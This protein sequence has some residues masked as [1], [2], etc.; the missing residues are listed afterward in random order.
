MIGRSICLLLPLAL[1]AAA[2][3]HKIQYT[4]DGTLVENGTKCLPFSKSGGADAGTTT[5]PTDATDGV[6]VGTDVKGPKTDKGSGGPDTGYPTSCEDLCQEYIGDNAPCQCDDGC[7]DAGDCCEDWA[8]FCEV[9]APQDDV[10]ADT[11]SDYSFPDPFD[12][13]ELSHGDCQGLASG[14]ASYCDSDDCKG[15]VKH[16]SSYC[17]TD[18]CKGMAKCDKGYCDSDDCK[19]IA[20]SDKSYCDSG[21]CKGIA[22]CHTIC[23][24]TGSCESSYCNSG[25][26]KAIA[27]QSKSYCP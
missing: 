23:E 14:D 21:D 2:C 24:G 22:S 6:P 3:E 13:S 12:P 26:C 15:I 5:T 20:S 19:G 9:V 1:G 25:Q 11:K 16:D 17:S 27:K 10:T 8:D 4:C 7:G 18:D